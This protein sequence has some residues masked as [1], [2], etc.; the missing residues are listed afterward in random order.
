MTLSSGMSGGRQPGRR[1]RAPPTAH[2]RGGPK[3]D[4]RSARLRR[5]PLM[6][7]TPSAEL[8]ARCRRQDEAAAEELFRRYAGR[9]TALARARL[10]RALAAR[11]GPEDVVQSAYR[12]FFLLARGGD[13]LLRESGD[14]WRLLV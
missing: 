10:S 7:D 13:V 6:S 11:V 2:A 3:M 5:I 8:V 14:L 12:S 4:R 9:L 1:G